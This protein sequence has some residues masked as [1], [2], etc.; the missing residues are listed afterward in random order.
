MTSVHRLIAIVIVWLVIAFLGAIM[1]GLALYVP[2]LMIT[3]VFVAT[4]LAGA[5]ATWAIAKAA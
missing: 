1:P 4:L 5:V 3:A 2:P